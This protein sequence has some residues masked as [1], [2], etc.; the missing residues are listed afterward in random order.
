MSGS[1]FL[2]IATDI[3]LVVLTAA[4]I[5]TVVRI[6]RGPTLPDRILAL[7]MLV[8]VGIGFIATL[9]VRTGFSLYLDI[10]ISLG[11]VGFLATVA[12]ARYVL[13]RARSE[14]ADTVDEPPA[15][16]AQ[17]ARATSGKGQ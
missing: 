5:L 13:Q 8:S 15:Q 9:S 6:M 16:Q 1:T 14:T 11:L 17:A 12:F 10:A 4:F 3:A 2:V 7:D